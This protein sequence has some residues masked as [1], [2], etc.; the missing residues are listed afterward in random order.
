M[1]EYHPPR[2]FVVMRDEGPGLGRLDRPVVAIGNFDGVHLGHRQVIGT[3]IDRARAAHRPAAVLTFEP[4][5]RTFFSPDE[6]SFHLSTEAAKLRLLAATGLDGAI[7]L[8]F[9]AALA[10]LTAE[11]FVQQ[12]LVDRL[13]VTGAVIGFNFHFGKAR[14]G[15]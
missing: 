5:P 12:I 4:H 1:T 15:T 10:S 13:A 6:P 14:R 8:T 2:P 7:L 11:E 3:A 9:D